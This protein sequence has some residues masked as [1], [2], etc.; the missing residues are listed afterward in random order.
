MTCVPAKRVSSTRK[1]SR[2]KMRNTYRAK[3]LADDVEL[4]AIF[5]NHIGD[6]NAIV[7][8]TR[9]LELWAEAS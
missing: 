9:Q 2:A 4:D 1:V 7:S 3:A 5:V 8:I 6:T